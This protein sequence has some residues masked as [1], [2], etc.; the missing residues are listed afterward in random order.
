LFAASAQDGPWTLHGTEI[1]PESHLLAQQNVKSNHLQSTIHVTLVTPTD[2]QERV[3]HGSTSNSD[4]NRQDPIG[5]LRRALETCQCRA[6]LDFCMTN[7]PFYDDAVST[8]RTDRRHGDGRD[9]TSMTVSEGSYP[10]GEVGFV[11]DMIVDGL[12]SYCKSTESDEQQQQQGLSC[13]AAPG[14]SSCMCGKKTSW[15]QLKHFVTELLGPAHVC[16]TEFTPGHLTRWFLAWTFEQPQ[17]KSPL[18][19]TEQWEF[20]VEETPWEQVMSRIE[21]YC[22]NLPCWKVSTIIVGD[23][24]LD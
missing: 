8:E 16:S 1:D 21:D 19:H 15:I 5:P 4:S 11:L 17:M 6:A 18:A 3:R 10:G 12:Y 13:V 24:M 20:T 22:A 9:R 23:C 14:W 2:A 7:P